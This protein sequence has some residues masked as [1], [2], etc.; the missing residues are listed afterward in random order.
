M[1]ASAG[2]SVAWLSADGCA[3]NGECTL[4]V[5]TSDYPDVDQVVQP[6]PGHEGFLPGGAADPS[7]TRIAAFVATSRGHAALAV[8]DTGILD[9]TLV[10]DSTIAVGHGVATA[11]WTPDDAY[12]LFSGPGGA[13]H[14]YGP[15][16]TRAVSLDVKGSSS[17]SVG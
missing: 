1:I 4:H 3:P 9:T 17:F 14:V 6:A 8:V 10:P 13:M 15:G 16:S 11:R 5:T 2:S 7:G 12:V